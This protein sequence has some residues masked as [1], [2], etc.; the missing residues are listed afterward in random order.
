MPSTPTSPKSRGFCLDRLLLFLGLGL[1]GGI[2]W[3]VRF[4][5]SEYPSKSSKPLPMI[6]ATPGS[7]T[8]SDVPVITEVD[9]QDSVQLVVNQ[10]A[11][12]VQQIQQE[13]V[14]KEPE[15]QAIAQEVRAIRTSLIE[16]RFQELDNQAKKYLWAAQPPDEQ[17]PVYETY[18]EWLY[19][20]ARREKRHHLL[21]WGKGGG[22]KVSPPEAEA[23]PAPDPGYQPD[24]VAE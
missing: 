19:L 6:D 7:V 5:L 17:D 4:S 15:V 20:K 10:A 2:T 22:L 11:Q 9:A 16:S 23:P 13:A 12:Q 14:Q 24:W 18:Q 8:V 3:F 1:L 21:G